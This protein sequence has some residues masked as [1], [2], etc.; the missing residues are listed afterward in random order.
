MASFEPSLFSW[1]SN[2]YKGSTA[3]I[4]GV[5]GAV[6]SVLIEGFASAGMKVA[7][8]ARTQ[9]KLD[10]IAKKANEKLGEGT[11]LA[12]SFDLSD[13]GA[14]GALFDRIEA[15]MPPIKAVHYNAVSI[16]GYDATAEAIA[17][18]SAINFGTIW[19]AFG[20]MVPRWK[21]KGGVFTM[22]GGGFDDDGAYSANFGLQFGATQ[23]A[24][25]KNFA[26]STSATFSA[27]GIHVCTMQINSMVFGGNMIPDE[28]NS[29]AEGAKAFEGR[30]QTAIV[31]ILNDT[32]A[33][34]YRP[35]N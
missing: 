20:A 22:S 27:D 3:V 34:C 30:L 6:G 13:T 28:L 18:S 14:V 8:V 5:G 16:I 2:G 33:V 19:G 11:V 17:K 1:K 31:D 15:S 24:F 25:M 12:F 10:E 9:S 29:D 23:K 21:G 32:T 7:I 26:Q 4:L 35:V